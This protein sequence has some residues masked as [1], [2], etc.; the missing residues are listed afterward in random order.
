MPHRQSD[1]VLRTNNF[2]SKRHFPQ[3]LCKN[4]YVLG[5]H[6]ATNIHTTKTAILGKN[7]KIHKNKL[8]ATHPLCYLWQV[9]VTQGH[10][11]LAGNRRLFLAPVFQRQFLASETGARKPASVSSLSV[12]CCRWSDLFNQQIDLKNPQNIHKNILNENS[13]F[14]FTCGMPYRSMLFVA[15]IQKPSPVAE[16]VFLGGSFLILPR[17]PLVP[18]VSFQLQEMSQ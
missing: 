5:K 11:T 3:I 16:M 17:L 13:I 2:K 1:D 12:Q 15:N 8:H 14:N 7:V 18:I 6:N 9:F 4:A 10:D